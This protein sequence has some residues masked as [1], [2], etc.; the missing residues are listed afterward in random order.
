LNEV[1]GLQIL[2][3]PSFE[4]L[5]D[6]LNILTPLYLGGFRAAISTLTGWFWWEFQITKTAEHLPPVG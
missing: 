1:T 2:G 3:I 5:T 4:H 6:N